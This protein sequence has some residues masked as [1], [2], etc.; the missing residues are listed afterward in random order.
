MVIGPDTIALGDCREL[1]K[2]VPEGSVDLVIM[3]PPYRLEN[4]GGGA[5]GPAN[6]TYHTELAPISGG[7]DDATLGLI[8]SRMRAVNLY[9]WCN[10][11]QIRQYLDYFEGLGCAT[12]LITWH[13]TNPTPTCNNKYL[14]D[15]EYCIFA[16]ERGVRVHGTYGTKRKYYVTP[17]NTADKVRYG[18]PTVKPLGIIR[19]L[20]I[21]SASPDGGAIVLDLFLG[22]GTTAVAAVEFGHH[23]IG[24]ESDPVH[25]AT[26]VRRVAGA[27]PLGSVSSESGTECAQTVLNE[28]HGVRYDDDRVS[29]HQESE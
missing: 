26:A 25:H 28:F 11:A 7:V 12:D 15:T 14:S 2:E 19:N 3:D 27:V 21:N 10:K 23:Y 18:H 4:S 9:V 20:V 13:K 22:S 17:L 6:R 29:Q 24:I 5:F 16:R 1:L 8:V